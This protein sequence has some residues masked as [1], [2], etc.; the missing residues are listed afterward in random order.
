MPETVAVIIPMFN[1]SSTVASTL[2]SVGLQSY[3]DIDIIVVD[4]GSTDDSAAVVAD[5]ARRDPRVRL[6][7]QPNLGVAAAR[8]AGAAATSADYFAFVDA[9]DLWAPAKLELQMKAFLEADEDV[10]AVYCWYALIDASATV[11]STR[12]QPKQEGMVLKGLCRT[13]F[14]GNGSSVL[15]KRAAFEAVGG[16][17]PSLRSR[18]AQGCEDYLIYLRIAESY[19]FKLV[20]RHLVGYR[21]TDHNMS[22]DALQM[23]R[24]FEIISAEYQ[25]RYPEF[26]TD[27]QAN[28]IENLHWILRRT[29]KAK[30]FCDAGRLIYRLA[31]VQ[32]WEALVSLPRLSVI[33]LGTVMPAW[34]KKG[35]R[36]SLF[37]STQREKSYDDLAW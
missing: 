9:D 5:C 2:H 30:N 14:V 36:R 26:R 16:Y 35:I 28:L 12:H 20:R 3:K 31:Q 8:N 27:L 15:L 17:D 37:R 1:A 23:I 4:D 7:R 18:H 13:N 11:L 19:R 34:L 22:S 21:L 10:G 25:A 33:C 32:F 29:L 6:L 24:S